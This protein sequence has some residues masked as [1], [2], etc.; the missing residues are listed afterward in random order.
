M[1][2]ILSKHF[3]KVYGIFQLAQK[4]VTS[5]TKVCLR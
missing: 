3:L 5:D 4:D 1:E 2:Q